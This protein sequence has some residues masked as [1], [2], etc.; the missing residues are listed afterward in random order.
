MVS[1]NS[2]TANGT[3]TGVHIQEDFV[4]TDNTVVARNTIVATAPSIAPAF[5]GIRIR[6]GSGVTVSDNVVTGP[7]QNSL[8][9]AN[10]TASV[11]VGN[12]FEGAQLYGVRMSAN[13]PFFMTQTTFRNNR[14]TGAA[15]AGIFALRACGNAFNGNNLN[16]N[17]GDLGLIFPDQS[18]AN[19]VS[20]NQ[21]VVIDNGAWDCNG[22]GMI[23]PNVIGGKGKVLHGVALTPLPEVQPYGILR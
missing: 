18:G 19:V 23:D 22:D 20:G 11:V 17:A 13:S 8:S 7:W 21:N 9:P 5:G 6:A 3:F 1:D 4:G 10:L 15:L 14:V 12:R 2:F 16:G